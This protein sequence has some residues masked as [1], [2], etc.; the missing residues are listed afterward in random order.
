GIEA[1]GAQVT[2][3][4]GDV[5]SS[6]DVARV[7]DSFH[8]AAKPLAGVIH[9]A[10]ILDDGVLLQQNP[11]RLHAVMA[12]KVQGALEISNHILPLS[13]D[14][15]VLY[16]SVAGLLG[17]AGQSGY[18]AANSFLNALAHHQR[19]RGKVALSVDWGA[20]SD[21]GM[22]AESSARG[23]RLAARGLGSLTPEEG[24][25]ALERLIEQDIAHIAVL[26]LDPATW[27]QA[28]PGAAATPRLSQLFSGAKTQ[29]DEPKHLLAALAG[30]GPDQRRRIL[31][32]FLCGVASS[33]LRIP[34]ERVDPAVSLTNLG[35]DSLMG[36]EFKQRLKRES[37]VNVPVSQLLDGSIASLIDIFVEALPES[38]Q[39]PDEDAIAEEEDDSW[40]VLRL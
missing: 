7:I 14:F 39:L 21:V 22:A 28:D 26:P 34:V 25:Q 8:H 5:S 35:L 9:A 15:F 36:L 11:Q 29:V 33:V 37:S 40:V 10:G 17:S 16:S 13:I 1:L 30:S 27:A 12:P 31:E 2:I 20:F 23:A 24:T 4:R 18:A 32:D 6:A 38:S 3:A 19:D